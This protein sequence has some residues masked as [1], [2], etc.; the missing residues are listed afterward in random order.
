L[1]AS[2]EEAEYDNPRGTSMG[3]RIGVS[4]EIGT[5]P[6]PDPLALFKIFKERSI[7][8]LSDSNM[9]Y[10]VRRV[11]NEGP[12]H[13]NVKT[14]LT[15]VMM[16]LSVEN[17]GPWADYREVMRTK[18]IFGVPLIPLQAMSSMPKEEL[19]L[20]YSRFHPILSM[21][22]PAVFTDLKRECCTSRD[23]CHGELVDLPAH[24][25]TDE[26]RPFASDLP[27]DWTCG[28]CKSPYLR[29]DIGKHQNTYM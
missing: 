29:P 23:D 10:L 24:L 28:T 15:S 20:P 18:T 19:V 5:I 17:S 16:M 13:S 9:K 7:S 12:R 4:G 27:V 8:E 25:C 1:N 3:V 11:Y 26:F 14:S 6:S 22:L 21:P 2:T